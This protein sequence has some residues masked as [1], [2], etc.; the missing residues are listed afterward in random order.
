MEV[1]PPRRIRWQVA[2]LILVGMLQ[3]CSG[4]SRSTESRFTLQQ[5]EDRSGKSTAK[6]VAGPGSPQCP[7]AGSPM[8]QPSASGTGHHKVVLT[9]NASAPSARPGGDIAGYCLYRSGKQDVAKKNATCSDCE[10]INTIPVAGTG[11]VDDL[12]QDDALYYYVVTAV[13][14]EGTRSMSSNEIP[15]EIKASKQNAGSISASSYPL[16]RGSASLK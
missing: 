10:Q 6:T 12:V 13:N 4:C 7:P 14:A 8:L 16:C 11:C 15:V 1:A 5:L 2:I 9:W 3:A